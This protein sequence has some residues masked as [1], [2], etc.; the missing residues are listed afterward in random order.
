MWTLEKIDQFDEIIDVRAPSEYNL[1]HI[2]GAHNCPALKNNERVTVGTLYRQTSAFEAKKLA[3]SMMTSNISSYLQ[4]YFNSRD[5]NW[6]PLVYCWRGGSRSEAFTYILNQIGWQTTQLSGGYKA[7][8]KMVIQEI[9]RLAPLLSFKVLCGRT[10]VG[11]SLLLQTLAQQGAQVL[12][13]EALANHRGSVLGEPTQGEQPTQ[14]W[15]ESLLCEALRHYNPQQTIFVEAESRKI[16]KLQVPTSL[17]MAIRNAPCIH[18]AADMTARVQYL[19]SE[20]HH[21]LENKALLESALSCLIPFR[22]KK[23]IAKWLDWKK[24]LSAETLVHEL[25]EEHYDPVY[26]RSMKHHFAHYHTQTDDS[27]H[28]QKIDR[29]CVKAAAEDLLNRETKK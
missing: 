11:K 5:A 7:Y 12:D 20:Y 15:F 10:G 23:Q 9:D 18:I 6:R 29:V 25:L 24:Q 21:F 2:P 14:K 1:D 13:L 16:G 22:G 17:L 8:R 28:L 26:L 27:I 19:I 4:H 3:A